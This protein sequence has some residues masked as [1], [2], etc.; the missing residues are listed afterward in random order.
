M[1]VTEYLV[2]TSAMSRLKVDAVNDRL[3]PLLMRGLVHTCAILE[4]EALYSAQSY[5]D[6]QKLSGW[7]NS[8]LRYEET[9]ER[10]WE[11]ALKVQSDLAADAQHRGASI[12]DL[13]IAAVA[14][15]QGLTV[16]HYDSDYEA[17]AA[18]T[19]QAHEWVVP[20]GSI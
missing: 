13:V 4:L 2:D 12:P 3:E 8:I 9:D 7:R 16:I 14:K 17:I 20:R 5:D 11:D 15:R 6:Y 18:V 10:D 1:A 19:G